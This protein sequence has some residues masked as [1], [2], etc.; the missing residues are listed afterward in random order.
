MHTVFSNRVSPPS[1]PVPTF[2]GLTG[3][4]EPGVIPR[5]LT[6]AISSRL[7]KT[8]LS[9]SRFPSKTHLALCDA[10]TPTGEDLTE[11]LLGRNVFEAEQKYGLELGMP[12]YSQNASVG[13]ETQDIADGSAASRD[14]SSIT[15]SFV[16]ADEGNTQGSEFCSSDLRAQFLPES[17]ERQEPPMVE[18]MQEDS[19]LIPRAVTPVNAAIQP[20]ALSGAAASPIE[21]YILPQGEPVN[22]ATGS[23]LGPYFNPVAA[24]MGSN[25]FG[26]SIPFSG[27]RDDK[28]AKKLRR[29]LRNRESAAR[30]NLRKQMRGK[31]LKEQIA[32]EV[33]KMEKLQLRLKELQEENKQLRRRVAGDASVR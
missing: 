1:D 16:R 15:N 8:V 9:P 4:N 10:F 11:I 19:G 28:E 18:T 21:L 32:A 12:N 7:S 14:G 20:D 25:N 3:G 6:W 22:Y 5:L 23:A 13:F 31:E 24:N 26:P 33:G 17:E 27:V 2:G 30:S 29:K